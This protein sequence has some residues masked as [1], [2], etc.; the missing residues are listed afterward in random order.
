MRFIADAML[1][2]MGRWLRMLGY[3]TIVCNNKISDDEIER[4]AKKEG[5]IILSRDKHIHGYYVESDD[6]KEQL[7][8]V[9]KEF[10]LKARFPEASRCSN[11]NGRLIK[12][13]R[14][15]VNVPPSV[16]SEVFF[17]CE[18]CG[19]VYWK[20]S[21]WKRIKEVIDYISS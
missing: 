21:H 5:R 17:Q 7:R 16:K 9:F 3:D 6:F 13:K 20:G 14:E 10:N 11:C 19:Q 15:E 12:V 2:K 18:N 8:Q 1:G 4:I